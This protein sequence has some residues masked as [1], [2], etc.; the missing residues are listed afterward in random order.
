MTLIISYLRQFNIAK[1]FQK[2]FI[3]DH[4]CWILQYV[5]YLPVYTYFIKFIRFL[6]VPDTLCGMLYKYYTSTMKKSR[7][8]WKICI[9]SITLVKMLI[10]N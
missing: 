8:L 3:R 6:F 1:V 10:Y 4:L 7:G 9:D 5:K 2:I